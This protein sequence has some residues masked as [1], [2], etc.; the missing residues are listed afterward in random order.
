MKVPVDMSED[1]PM[2]IPE[3]LLPKDFIL[4]KQ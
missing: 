1:M 2:D 4:T 3:G